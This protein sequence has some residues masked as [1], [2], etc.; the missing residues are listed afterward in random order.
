MLV[1]IKSSP[2][3]PAGRRGVK[4]A[5]N[6]RADIALIQNGVY[7]LKGSALENLNYVGTA[8]ALEDDRRLRGL[9]AVDENINVKEINYDGLVDLLAESDKV[10][11]MF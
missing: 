11:G 10:I 8:Y 5:R 1:I 7:F 4:T 3:T 2:D 6:L 9:G